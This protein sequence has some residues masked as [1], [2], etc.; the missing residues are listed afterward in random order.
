MVPNPNQ[1]ID[2]RMFIRKHSLGDRNVQN[3]PP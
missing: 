1:Y 2:F 3:T